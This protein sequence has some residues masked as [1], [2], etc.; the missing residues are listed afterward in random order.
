MVEQS[1]DMSVSRRRE[2]SYS[3]SLIYV[4]YKSTLEVDRSLTET[5]RRSVN[6]TSLLAVIL[7]SYRHD[8]FDSVDLP[9]RI[10]SPELILLSSSKTTVVKLITLIIETTVSHFNIPLFSSLRAPGAVVF[11]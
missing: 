8:I 4:V 1:V 2:E 6:V 7:N 11:C 3:L 9:V 5:C 10:Y